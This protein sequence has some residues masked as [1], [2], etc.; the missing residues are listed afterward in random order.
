M[1]GHYAYGDHEPWA[2]MT[3]TV[4][5]RIELH[6]GWNARSAEDRCILAHELTHFLQVRNGQHFNPEA[7]A[8]PAAYRVTALCFAGYHLPAD[9]V[10]WAWGQVAKFSAEAGWRFDPELRLVIRDG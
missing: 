6:R 10:R 1:L 7:G 4:T 3:D 5:G 2:G 8:E 9:E